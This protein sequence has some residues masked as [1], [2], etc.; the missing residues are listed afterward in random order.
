MS[1]PTPVS[2]FIRSNIDKDLDSGR[3]A[4]RQWGGKP[5]LA[6]SHRAG[7]PDP[8]TIR[9][10]FPPEPNGYLHIGHAKAICV[11]FGLASDYNG[12]CHLRFD[13]TNPAREEQEF[14][15]AIIDALQ[16]LGFSWENDGESN[17]YFASDYF[18]WLYL[19]AEHLIQA[20]HAYVDSQSAEDIRTNRGNLT[21]PGVESPFRNRTARE[22]LDLFREMRDGKHA[23]GAHILRARI[24]MASANMNMRDPAL[25]RIRHEHHHRTGD[26]WCIY[27]MY[28]FAHPLEDGLEKITHSL[29]S[30]EFQDHRPFYEWILNRVA[31]AGFLDQPLPR[32]IEF[33][34][35]NLEHTI[36]SK[37]KIQTLVDGGH[38]SGWDDPRLATLAG[39][40]RRGYSPES[41]RLFCDRIGIS[42]AHQWIE[43]SAL[44]QALRDDLDNRAARTIAVLNPLALELTNWSADKVEPCSAP[45]HP[46][47][48]ERG[49]REFALTRELWIEREDFMEEPVKGFFR[50]SPGK[51]V[52][53]RYGFV[54]ECTGF[55]KNADGQVVKVLAKVMPDS[56]SG[57][58]G[59][60]N[61]KVKGNLHWLSASSARAAVIRLYDRLFTDP[62]P[63][64]GGKDFLAALNPD[65]IREV[66]A[67]VDLSA[68]DTV[69]PLQFERHGYFVADSVDHTP[70]NPVFN[71]AV[72]LK[73]SWRTATKASKPAKPEKTKKK[74]GQ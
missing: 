60:D 42:K 64:E 24:D 39:L 65:S 62:A 6:E 30:L 29:C 44:E 57:T 46:H 20:G 14:V 53:L 69:Q 7:P 12:R 1:E 38:V 66:N 28:D 36:M 8:A 3:Y 32:Q 25:Y 26:R 43:Y 47:F 16:W 17:L 41:I 18:D 2:N 54:I 19:F 11:N 27:P 21:N 55:E 48:P 5:G 31:E 51:Q 52:R 73:D 35:L 9:T 23:D 61:Y 67:F 45:V 70:T 72:T 50:L 15:N 10:R 49:R 63:D 74:P 33:A 71:R 40:R 68:V 13:D 22:N 37:R 56:K 34:R 4:S 58:P 59:A